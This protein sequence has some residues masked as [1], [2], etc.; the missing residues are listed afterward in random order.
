MDSTLQVNIWQVFTWLLFILFTVLL[1]FSINLFGR[2]YK[3]KRI[4][5][6]QIIEINEKTGIGINKSIY[7]KFPKTW[8]VFNN[9]IDKYFP[10]GDKRRGEVLALMS[11]VFIAMDE[12]VKVQI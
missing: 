9:E 5:S 2:K 11:F 1:I 10:K 4:Q 7:D 12:E 8:Q 3:K 6:Y